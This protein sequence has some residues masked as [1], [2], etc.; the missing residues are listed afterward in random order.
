MWVLLEHLN[1]R[2]VALKSKLE[3]Q[4]ELKKRST[5]IKQLDRQLATKKLRQFDHKQSLE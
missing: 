5:Y 3:D 1:N 4:A 2:K